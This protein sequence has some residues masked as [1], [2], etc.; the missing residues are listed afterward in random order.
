VYDKINKNKKQKG[1]FVSRRINIKNKVF[2][3]LTVVSFSHNEN[4]H[5]VWNVKCSCGTE[6]KVTYSNLKS[7]NTTQCKSCSQKTHGL[8]YTGYYRK[9]LSMRKRHGLENIDN[10]W[11]TFE[12]FKQDTFSTYNEGFRLKRLDNTKPFSKKNCCWQKTRVGNNKSEKVY[13]RTE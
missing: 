10:N 3:N 7:K 8:T 2:G 12:G 6:F 11:H 1:I 13:F 5:A 9:Y 4:S